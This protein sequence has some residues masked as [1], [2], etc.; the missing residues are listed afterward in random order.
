MKL[1]SV[2]AALLCS[3]GLLATPAQTGDRPRIVSIGGAVT[4]ILFALGA[5]SDIVGCDSTSDFPGAAADLPK[6]GYQRRFSSEGVLSLQPTLVLASHDAGPPTAIEQVQAAGVPVTVVSGEATLDG[7]KQK[8]RAI[9][10]AAGKADAGEALVAK[11]EA[12]IL[13]TKRFVDRQ[14]VRPKVLFVYARGPGTILVAGKNTSADSIIRMAGGDNP[15]T[16]YE[17]YK[18]MTAEAVVS[19]AP[20]VVLMLS[21]GLESLGG[22]EDLLKAPD[23]A[24][25]PA[26]QERRVITMDGLYLLG[27]G[28]RTGQA[29]YDL[30]QRLVEVMT[31]GGES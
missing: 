5:E 29:A 18:P 17:G 16:E 8:V 7:V 25:T 28:P 20:D 21:S 31:D 15:V 26:G 3:I 10:E 1:T 12:D 19:A 27:F 6:V 30:A 4:E 14:P 2:S 24:L 22:V 13:R 11:I 23:L 9:A